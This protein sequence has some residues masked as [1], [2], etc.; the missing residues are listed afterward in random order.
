M[1]ILTFDTSSDKTYVT[2]GEDSRI[3]AY[4]IVENTQQFYSAAFLI[5][6][7]VELL[8][9]LNLT[10]QDIAA[11]GVNI[12]P[13]S[14]TGIRVS[15]TV[16]KTIGQALDIPIVGISC[17]AII[18][19]INNTDKNTLCLFDAKRGKAYIGIYTSE[20]DVIQE[21]N[22]LE[23]DKAVEYAKNTDF[24]IIADNSMSEKLKTAG[25]EYTNLQEINYNLGIYLA[26]LTCKYL[27][28]NNDDKYKW[29]NLNP[30]YIQPPPISMPK[31]ICI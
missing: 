16:A 10:M 26:R 9:N 29:S 3:E 8:Q 2:I 23:Y 22:M 27:K 15:A 31:T 1:K 25:I 11:V 21:P 12:G 17:F 30:L 18:S 24:Y 5:P 13:G 14:F 6:T 28:Q 4:K 7:I 20:G 19:L